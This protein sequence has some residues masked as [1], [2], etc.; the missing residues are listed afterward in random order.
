MSAPDRS[1][2]ARG[3]LA[4]A[5]LRVV[6]VPLV[7]I[8]ASA[9]DHPTPDSDLFAPLLVVVAIWAVGLLVVHAL[10][11]AGRVPRPRRLAR[12]EP[13]VD[14]LALAALTYTSGGPYSEARLA[15]FALPLVAAF[16]LQPALTAAWTG[17][18]IAAY[19]LISLPHPATRSSA[20]VDAI[21]AHALFLAWA[22]AGAVVL[23][24]LLG[25]R[26]RR[27]RA[28]AAERGRLVAQALT[29][30]EHERRRLAE[31]LHDETIQNLLLARHELRDHHRRHDEDSFRRADSALAVT[32][33]QL[34]GEVFE[35]HPYVLDHAGLR[36]ALTSHAESAAR[37]AGAL[38][39]VAVGDVDLTDAQQ[40]LVLSLARELLS[41]AARHARAHA[42]RLQLSAD[43]EAVVLVVADDGTGLA[44]E[45]RGEAL[46]E[47]HIGLATSSERA[48]AAGGSLTV[49]SA[50]GAGTTITVRLPRAPA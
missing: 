43:A 21:V 17:A 39:D 28:A 12:A 29:A 3:E 5:L 19:V 4:M 32:V 1:E 40:Q 22:G 14:L 2:G 11:A 20:D 44:P 6:L 30:E 8:G 27:L 26:D 15:F 46:A 37:R 36:A 34:R 45:R 47:G 33:E 10:A 48:A 7:A 49:D 31:L 35:M 25:E 23:S 50:P 16:R 38:A 18:A 9:V 13:V 41:N 24:A 42:I